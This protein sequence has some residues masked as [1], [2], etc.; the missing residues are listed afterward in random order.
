MAI[1]SELMTIHG[2]LFLKRRPHGD[3]LG[4]GVKWLP[5]QVGYAQAGCLG[6]MVGIGRIWGRCHG[7]KSHSS[8]GT[9]ARGAR[10]AVW[11]YPN[12]RRPANAPHGHLNRNRH[13]KQ[14]GRPEGRPDLRMCGRITGLGLPSPRQP[15]PPAP[16]AP[17]PRWRLVHPRDPESPPSVR[18]AS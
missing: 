11:W 14:K 2:G 5:L 9:L 15:L 7:R 4:F 8:V 6:E 1:H 13:I 18:G 3:Q 16:C 10:W 17:Q 12:P